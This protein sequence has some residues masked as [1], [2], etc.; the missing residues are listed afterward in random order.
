MVGEELVMILRLEPDQEN[1]APLREALE[2]RNRRLPDFKRVHR[3]L[4]W[5]TDFPRTA[6]MKIKRNDLADNIR[7]RAASEK[8]AVAL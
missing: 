3:Y 1:D 4:V 5:E 8:E 2:A 6:S 7:A